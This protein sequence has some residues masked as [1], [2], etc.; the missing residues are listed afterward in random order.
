ML[1][2]TCLFYNDENT[3]VFLQN[4]LT[5]YWNRK[6]LSCP[7]ALVA[8]SIFQSFTGKNVKV[9]DIFN[10]SNGGKTTP[11]LQ[12]AMARPP[13]SR[14]PASTAMPGL[15]RPCWQPQSFSSS[16]DQTH[17]WLLH[18]FHTTTSRRQRS[19]PHDVPPPRTIRSA[20]S[21]TAR[22]QPLSPPHAHQQ[23][24]GARLA[25]CCWPPG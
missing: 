1:S 8:M 21:A 7:Y 24:P 19:D 3:T 2:K 18:R 12:A 15:P 6:M 5:H 14:T 25:R 20:G 9:T 4:I 22:L 11:V 17:P 10:N 13:R 23:W 16:T